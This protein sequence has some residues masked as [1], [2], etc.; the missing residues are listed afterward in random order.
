MSRIALDKIPALTFYKNALTKARRSSAIA[1]LV[2]VGKP[3]TLYQPE[4][5]HCTN[6]GGSGTDVDWRVSTPATTFITT[7]ALVVAHTILVRG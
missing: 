7:N 3:C 6:V 1:Q 4:V 2:C 5:V